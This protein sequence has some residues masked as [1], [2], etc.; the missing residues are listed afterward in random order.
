[1]SERAIDIHI[2]KEV[3][4]C[5]FLNK[6]LQTLSTFAFFKHKESKRRSEQ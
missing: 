5:L 2:F 3:F 4:P 6:N 1:M